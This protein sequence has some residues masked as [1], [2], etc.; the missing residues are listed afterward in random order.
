MQGRRPIGNKPSADGAITEP[1]H[2][3]GGSFAA[4]GFTAWGILQAKE[5]AMSIA[6]LIT[7]W[8]AKKDARLYSQGYSDGLAGRPRQMEDPGDDRRNQDDPPVR[9]PRPRRRNLR[10]RP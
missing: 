4:A 10:R 5:L 8:R 2:S 9:P 1:D 6:Q 7:D 3:R